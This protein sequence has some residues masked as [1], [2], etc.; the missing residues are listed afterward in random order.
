MRWNR[1]YSNDG[2]SVPGGTERAEVRPC[3]SEKK[4]AE[5]A[6]Y[7]PKCGGSLTGTDP[8]VDNNAAVS[9]K[10]WLATFLLCWFLGVFGIHRFYVGKTGSAIA[11]ILTLGGFG[12]WV[13]VDWIIIL[14]GDF[15]DKDG[16]VIKRR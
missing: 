3:H 5:D 9:D 13:L 6:A 7:C 8:L 14:C 10:D 1:W 2:L 4:L 15:K 12:I 11:M 16:R